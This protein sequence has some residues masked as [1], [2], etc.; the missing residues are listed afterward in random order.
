M[1]VGQVCGEF[2]DAL[3]G[4]FGGDDFDVVPELQQLAHRLN[5]GVADCHEPPSVVARR[6]ACQPSAQDAA[7][8]VDA[9]FSQPDC[10]VDASGRFGALFEFVPH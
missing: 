5:V 6:G 7:G 8:E 1:S 10:D 3:T 9:T 2:T 4:A